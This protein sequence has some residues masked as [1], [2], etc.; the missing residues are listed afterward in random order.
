M[1]TDT[2]SENIFAV[3]MEGLVVWCFGQNNIT[4][5]SI[6]YYRNYKSK[7]IQFLCLIRCF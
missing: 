3:I 1:E 6:Y 5:K 2:V 4:R 7:Y